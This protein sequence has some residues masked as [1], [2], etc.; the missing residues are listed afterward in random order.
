M[1]I[2]L[3]GAAWQQFVQRICNRHYGVGA[4]GVLIV[5]G[6]PQTG[7][8]E[9]L[10]FNAD[11]TQAENCLNGLRCVAHYL[12]MTYHFP[13]KFS[14]KIG[15]RIAECAV[16]QDSARQECEI[17]TRVGAVQHDGERE[18]V[19]NGHIL[20]GN[21]ASIGNPHFI[22][23]D[24]RSLEWVKTHGPAIE[25][26]E[27][28]AH[29]TNV[30]F[31]WPTREGH[32]NSYDIIVFERGCGITLACSSGAACITS[33]LVQKNIITQEQKIT[34]CMQG[35]SVTAWLDAD[36]SV[37]LQALAQPIF[38]GTFQDQITASK[39]LSKD[40]VLEG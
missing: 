40:A 22:V 26:H 14:I 12:F 36:G 17:V 39:I 21:V 31:V 35:G 5:T 15:P 4:D 30:E 10:I 16:Y 23:F 13:Q 1:Q 3:Q 24:K 37:V 32:H 9:I 2:E 25:S 11:G 20:K 28:F 29:K 27:A 7:M 34:L 8:P 19:V 18:I 38:N 6:F 33:L